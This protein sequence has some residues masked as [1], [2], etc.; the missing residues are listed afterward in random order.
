MVAFSVSGDLVKVDP[1]TGGRAVPFL[2]PDPGVPL[3]R[4]ATLSRLTPEKAWKTQPS[5]RKVVGFIA[6]NVASVPWKAFERVDDDDRRRVS[7]SPAESAFRVPRR[8]TTGYSLLY[9]LTVDRCMYDRAAIVLVD[10]KPRR[11]PGRSLVVESNALDEI[12]FVGVN[13]AGRT[14][15]LTELP[16][17]V[18]TGWD[19]W[20]GDGISPLKT[21]DAI[22]REQSEAVEWRR[23]QWDERPK[24]SGI[25]KRPATAPK[26]SETQRTRWVQSFR[27][28]RDGQ[29]GGAPVFEDGMEW[30][31]WSSSFSPADALDIEGRKLTDAEV[32]SAFYVP[33]ELVGAR[34]GTFSN[35]T[36]FRQMLF[37]PVLGPHFTEFEQGLNAE[38]I[39][40]LGGDGVYGEF[41]RQSAINGSLLEQAKLLSTAVGGPYMTRGEARGALNLPKKDGTEELITPLNVIVGG[42]ASP[43]D[44]TTGGG[45]SAEPLAIDAAAKVG[46]FTVDELVKL[47]AAANG[48]IRSGFL[49]EKALEAVGLNP[50]EHSG[51][52]PVT[53]RDDE[54]PG[55]GEGGSTSSA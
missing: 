7:K 11:I 51:L 39:P 12:D 13:V 8:F 24:F 34:E 25:V 1:L 17:A 37:G 35:I 55:G 14:V 6:R 21:L 54:K 50:I 27:E 3:T 43:Q 16:L 36:A 48:L 47:I 23:R 46:G 44:G 19:A 42:Q 26:W 29:A 31:D 15:D 40:A 10:G 4:A 41:D 32:A 18:F 30:E 45:G 20:S 2:T 49:P 38:V 53:V 33:P 9:R 22:L 52:L 28:F 5:I